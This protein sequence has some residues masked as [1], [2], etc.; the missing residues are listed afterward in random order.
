MTTLTFR[1]RAAAF[2][3]G[4]AVLLSAAACS[5]SD[6]QGPTTSREP[7]PTT[8]AP[9]TPG[10]STST[11][12][13]PAD[14]G[15]V[16][17]LAPGEATSSAGN[18]PFVNFDGDAAVFSHRVVSVEPASPDALAVLSSVSA[19]L[20]E[21]DI[22]FVGVESFYVA[23]AD[24]A[25]SSFTGNFRP[26]TADLGDVKSGSIV[27]YDFCESDSIPSPGNDPATPIATCVL[28][29]VSPGEPAPAGVAWSA[30]DTPYDRYD[31]TPAYFLLG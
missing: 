12:S 6:P 19:E 23:G 17:V 31:G 18:V 29:I 1:R 8:D 22:Y 21:Y 9:A 16:P 4:A 30:V 14:T 10:P 2:A 3:V 5:S 26:V 20:A 25:Y 28:A 24:L 11:T 27:G 13:A 7:T 15:D